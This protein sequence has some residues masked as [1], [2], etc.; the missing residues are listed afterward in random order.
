MPSNGKLHKHSPDEYVRERVV[1]ADLAGVLRRWKH[2]YEADR[3]NSAT[4]LEWQGERQF[5]GAIDQ[6]ARLTEISQRR[7]W[8]I[9]N[10][11]TKTTSLWLA[12]RL[13]VSIGEEHLLRTGDIRVLEDFNVHNTRGMSNEEW[14]AYLEERGD[15]I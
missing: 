13:L 15:C 4:V 11:Q 6:L 3:P 8:A 9:V 12:D 10:I 7:I 1:T 5:E 14:F 2:E